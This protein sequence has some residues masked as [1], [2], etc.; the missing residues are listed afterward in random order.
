MSMLA[1]IRRVTPDIL[2]GVVEDPCDIFWFLLGSEPYEPPRGIVARLF[3]KRKPP[4]TRPEWHKPSADYLFSLD[5]SWH[6]VHFLLAGEAEGGPL[7][8]AFLASGGIRVHAASDV[9]ENTGLTLPTVSKLLKALTRAGLVNSH[10]GSHGGYALAYPAEEITAADVVDALEG[11]LAIT[12]CSSSDSHC[13]LQPICRVG[14]ALQK[15]NQGIQAVLESITLAQ[16]TAVPEVP[17]RRMDPVS[18]EK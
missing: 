3:A 4:P 7:P 11:P 2:A 13:E 18:L 1:D 16:L 9:A 12:E 17:L 14:G 6:C 15:L 5:N 10:R 8:A